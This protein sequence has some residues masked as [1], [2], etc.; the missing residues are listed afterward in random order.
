[1]ESK[2]TDEFLYGKK[3]YMLLAGSI[4]IIASGFILMSGGGDGTTYT[5]EI[6][7]VSRITVAPTLIIIG[8]L[9]GL[10]AT[11]MSNKKESCKA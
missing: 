5:P 7:S 2:N 6:F 1:M 4:V 11:I 8:Y 10:Y 9:M 3:N